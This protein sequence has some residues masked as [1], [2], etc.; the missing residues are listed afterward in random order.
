MLLNIKFKLIYRSIIPNDFK[1]L[2]KFIT[3]IFVILF[4]LISIYFVFHKV[5]VFLLKYEDIGYGLIYRIF[6]IMFSMFFILLITSSII[7]SISTFFRTRELEFLFSTPININYLFLNK[8]IENGFYASWATS[9][10]SIPIIFALG[11][12]FDMNIY[13]YIR[14]I[15]YFFLLVIIATSIGLS[16]VFFFSNFFLKYSTGSLI[17]LLFLFLCLILL[18]LF[19]Y[20]SPDIF[21]LPQNAT[22]IEINNYIASLEV[23]QF[24]LLPS[25]I[26]AQSIFKELGYKNIDNREFYLILYII[27][28]FIIIFVSMILYKNKYLGTTYIKTRKDNF[29]KNK[30]ISR[31]RNIYW[32]L[33][34]KDLIVFLRDPS[35]WGQSLIFLILLIFYIISLIRSPIYF[36]TAFYT[37]ILAFANMG[38]SSYIT[39]TLSVRFIFPLISLEGKNIE[40]IKMAIPIKTYI[41]AKLIFNF[42]IVFLLSEI[43]I[44]GT[45]LFLTFDSFIIIISSIF[46]FIM[47]I[48]I[49]FLNTSIGAI[50]PDF[51][52][53]NPSKIASGFGGI[54]A[55]IFSLIYIG[56]SLSIMSAP[57]RMYFEYTFRGLE[58]NKIYFII[59]LCIILLITIII[60]IPI[61]IFAIKKF[62][63][64]TL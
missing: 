45:N 62:K 18:S 33:I 30:I 43:L 38:F 28:T 15:L 25:G 46:V 3:Y 2:I 40:Y 54:I 50:F 32:V 55:A 10:L 8:L 5:F 52:E 24:K 60:I 7:S 37:Y 17:I 42:V 63:R 64:M 29:K 1:S 21:N 58:F 12:A 34:K 49:S 56:V 19:F 4:F 57:T 41:N 23:E 27:I 44:T 53:N 48:G 9:L 59:S 61:Y 35:Q 47:S 39:A 16:L 22:L 26:I 31:F 13:F 14:G 6:S 36:R 51:N 11:H 20:K